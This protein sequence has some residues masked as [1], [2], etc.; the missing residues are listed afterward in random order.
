MLDFDAVEENKPLLMSMSAARK[1]PASQ[2][3]IY[4]PPQAEAVDVF[5]DRPALHETQSP[6]PT[7]SRGSLANPLPPKMRVSKT[8]RLPRP[9]SLQMRASTDSSLLNK[10]GSPFSRSLSFTSV[11]DA[12]HV[13]KAIIRR[14]RVEKQLAVALPAPLLRARGDAAKSG[15]NSTAV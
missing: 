6:P 1:P 15:Y 9:S 5:E 10:P 13:R 12:R 11:E 7:P 14:H 8:S 3:S 4:S 2:R